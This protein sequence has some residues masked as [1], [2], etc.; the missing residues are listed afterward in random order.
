MDLTNK[1]EKLAQAWKLIK[2]EQIRAN[3]TI[4]AIEAVQQSTMYVAFQTN[5]TWTFTIYSL[6]NYHHTLF[7]PIADLTLTRKYYKHK[8]YHDNQAL[9]EDT[10]LTH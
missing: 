1:N 4:P 5:I 3:L 9:Q 10:S 6:H 2:Q 7:L 8:R